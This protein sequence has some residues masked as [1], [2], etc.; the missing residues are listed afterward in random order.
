MFSHAVADRLNLN[1]TDF[2]C[3]DV[4]DWRGP[5]TAGKL[6]DDLGLTT[7][8]VTGILDRMEKAGYVRRE[9]DPHDRRRVIVHL[10]RSAEA[11]RVYEPFARSMSDLFSSFRENDLKVIVEF[12]A[13]CNRL[14]EEQ[15]IRLR[16]ETKADKQKGA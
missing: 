8:A 7:G 9:R 10:N 2:E 13:E 5:T 11:L 14:F 4:L 1:L 6:A 12:M 15:I 3:L 16:T